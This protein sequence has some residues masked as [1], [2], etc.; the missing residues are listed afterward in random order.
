MS[1]VQGDEAHILVHTWVF[2]YR[3]PGSGRFGRVWTST[4]RGAWARAA[5]AVTE[6]TADCRRV[7]M[8]WK[9]LYVP[10]THLEAPCDDL[11]SFD[12]GGLSTTFF[13]MIL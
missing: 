4:P 12:S 5:V 3:K 2:R 10:E 1:G 6:G 7:F 13:S 11:S 8:K 9:R